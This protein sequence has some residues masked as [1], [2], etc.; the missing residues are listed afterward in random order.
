KQRRLWL[1]TQQ[2]IYCVSKAALNACADGKT[3]TVNFV[4][5][6]G[7]PTLECSDRYQPTCWRGRD[8]RLLFSTVRGVVSVN[9]EELKGN[10]LPPPVVIE[11]FRM[12]GEPV[13]LGGRK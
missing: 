13:R 12:D 10:S 1:G 3:N 6:G 5:F 11:E 9:P 7:L 2:G 4:S 8:G